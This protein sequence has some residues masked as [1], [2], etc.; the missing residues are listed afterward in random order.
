MQTL[1][2]D[3][4]HRKLWDNQPMKGMGGYKR[5]IATRS[6]SS[7]GYGMKGVDSVDLHPGRLGI[8]IST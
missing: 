3:K 8:T 1:D 6:Q 5:G 2:C 4:R 7:I